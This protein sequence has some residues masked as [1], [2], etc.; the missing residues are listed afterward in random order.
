[1]GVLPEDW[2]HG[3]FGLYL[4]W[5]YCTAK[6]PYC[7]FNSHVASQVDH[8]GWRRAYISEI[9]R[10]ARLTPGRRLKSIYFGGGT[11]SLMEAET[12]AAVI[13]AAQR[14]WHLDNDAEITLEANPGSVEAGKFADFRAAGVNR[15]SIG[16][17]ALND[18][19]LQRLGRIH[20][21]AEARAAIDTGLAC[22]DRVNFDLIYGR[23]DQGL[24]AWSAELEE[25]LAIGSDHLSL[26]QLTIEDGTP[27][28]RRQ[29]SGGLKGL[30]G[31]DLSAEMY[32][33]T[34]EICAA[35]GLRRYEVSNFARDGQESRHNLIY[36]RY[37]DYAGI[38]PGAHG[39]LT[40]GGQRFATAGWRNPGRWLN[41]ASS[42]QADE[43]CE[44]LSGLEQAEECLLMGL[45][46]TEGVSLDRLSALSGQRLTGL[47]RLAD[48]GAIQV[49]D[50]NIIVLK[51]YV[52]LLN[53]ILGDLC[54]E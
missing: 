21:A 49:V 15:V 4:H 12:V 46:T 26:Y 51:Q 54:F 16:V 30:P 41:A 2:E 6:C 10:I 13:T 45:R 44:P 14:A 20:T 36:W 9:D 19:D 11:P 22:F 3:G 1:M 23:Q 53:Q 5:P 48:L 27:F 43:T 34:E 25:A 28:A 50:G 18:P 24:A 38:G 40:L 17:Q 31:D 7:D 47:D 42:G 39:R 52:I 8:A 29:A 35:R 33:A 37:G 32:A